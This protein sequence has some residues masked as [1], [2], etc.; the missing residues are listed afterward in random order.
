MDLPIGAPKVIP[1][2]DDARECW[3]DF[4]EKVEANQGE[5]SNYEHMTDWT[6]KLPGA[7]VRM[8][9]LMHIAMHGVHTSSIGLDSMERAVML[10]RLL[11]KHAD[12]AFSLMG[13]TKTEGDAM[14]VYRWIKARGVA[15]FTKR[16][17]HKA[18]QGR[19]RTVEPLTAALKQLAD[20]Y[21]IS[22]VGCVK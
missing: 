10:G 21:V 6:S 20:Q 13:A 3:L 12:A 18:L 11:T 14:H 22:R 16:D 19:F 5:G 1:L 7:V 4:R 8:A 15:E 9:G 2:S 17:I